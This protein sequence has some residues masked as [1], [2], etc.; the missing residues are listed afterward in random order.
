MKYYLY[1]HTRLDTNRVFYIGIGTKP[2]KFSSITLEFSRAYAKTGRNKFWKNIICKTK[3][4]VEILLESNDYEFIKEKEI[5]FVKLY[6]RRNLGLGSLVNLTDGGEGVKGRIISIEERE[7]IRKTLT[8]RKSTRINYRHSQET[9]DNISKRAKERKA[10]LVLGNKALIVNQIAVSQYD[11]QG[12][13]ISSFDS[14]KLAHLATG[15]SQKTIRKQLRNIKPRKK[16]NTKY[17]WKYK[18]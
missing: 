2:A 8:G 12:N 4:K 14:L 10:H 15:I 13:F 16:V 3:Y 5:E 18:Q 1:Q 17:L 6:G 7:Q 11:L 9:K